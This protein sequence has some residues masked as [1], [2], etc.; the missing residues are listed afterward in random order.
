MS[1]QF[2]VG[3][4]VVM[5]KNNQYCL[6]VEGSTGTVLRI[7][8]IEGLVKWDLSTLAAPNWGD[9]WAVSSEHLKLLAECGTPPPPVETKIIKKIKELDKAFAFRQLQKKGISVCV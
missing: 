3:D 9:E 5:I 1:N 6:T 8:P 2:N 7:T 4:R